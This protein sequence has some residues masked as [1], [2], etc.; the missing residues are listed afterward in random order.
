MSESHNLAA[1]LAGSVFGSFV[2]DS[3]AL[4]VHW[5]YNPQKIWADH[6]RITTYIDPSGNKYHKSKKAGDFTHYGD[7]TL[8]LM[9]SI[10]TSFDQALFESHWKNLWSNDYNGYIDGATRETLN[11]GLSE[12]DDI[13]GASRIA[14][15]LVPYSG[16]L[17]ERELIKAVESQTAFT[18]NHPEVIESAV[19]F[20]TLTHRIVQ[21]EKFEAAL[22]A[23]AAQN[24]QFI[25]PIQVIDDVAEELDEETGIAM[26]ARGLDCHVAS[27][28]PATIYILVKYQ[29]SFESAL[30]ENTMAGGDS[31]ARGMI[32]GMV[33]G[34]L[35]G[36]GAIPDRWLSG[37]RAHDDVQAWLDRFH[38]L[39]GAI[40]TVD[41][42]PGTNKFEFVNRKGMTLAGL[43]E[44]PSDERREPRAVAVLAHCFTC[45][46]E[47][48]AASRIAGNLACAGFAVLRFDF[49]GLGNSEGDF[50]N[51]N[52][53]SNVEDLLAAAENVGN[54]I[55]KPVELLIGHSLGGAAVLAG[56]R[57][58]HDV[59]GI[60]TIGA[61][62]DAA[63]VSHLFEQNLDEIEANGEAEV[64][65]A[66]RTFTIK[67]QFLDD[68]R[69]Q[70]ILEDLSEFRG[71]V[72]IMHSPTDA[73]VDVEHAGKI[74]SAAKHPKSFI[75]LAGA[76]HLLTDSKDS[77]FVADI[78]SAWAG[79]LFEDVLPA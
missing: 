3:L 36:V 12:S 39:T 17:Q 13:S 76:D 58:L 24:W 46:K 37:L 50:G 63:H 48:I 14:P 71:A 26:E 52:F 69:E 65:L 73:T 16:K 67:R 41:L 8:E 1:R 60:V 34:A 23:V 7:Q 19:F 51:T 55:G 54:S 20:A 29:E 6:G 33:L 72:L 49:T 74:Y 31:A 18:H 45:S 15:L 10:E 62:S 25:D 9:R 27:A 32:I 79:H 35:H 4:A 11:T 53:S 44:W 28:F 30:I 77:Q 5:I 38:V 61:P 47:V 64:N 78:I 40:P 21:G 56:A 75:S 59:K 68:V 57:S 43:M 66:G 70:R 2:G 22:E 42:Q